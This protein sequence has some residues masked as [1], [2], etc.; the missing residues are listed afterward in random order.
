MFDAHR[1]E[2]RSAVRMQL[3]HRRLAVRWHVVGVFAV[4]AQQLLQHSLLNPRNETLGM[5]VAGALGGCTLYIET[6]VSVI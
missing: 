1:E 4:D 3:D 6:S 5:V 2:G